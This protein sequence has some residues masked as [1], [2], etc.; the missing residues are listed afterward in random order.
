VVKA[1]NTVFAEQMA[2]GAVHEEPLTVFAAGDDRQARRE[3]ISLAEAIGFE[4]T[5]AGPPENARYLA[6][7]AD[8]TMQLAHDQEIGSDIGFHLVNPRGG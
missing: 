4:A 6:S 7:M 2:S 8:L 1:F 3:V 5:E